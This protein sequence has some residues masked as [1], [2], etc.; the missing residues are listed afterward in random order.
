MGLPPLFAF[1]QLSLLL[2][3][4][5][6]KDRDYISLSTTHKTSWHTPSY[7]DATSPYL[8]WDSQ[9]IAIGAQVSLHECN[10][11]AATQAF[12]VQS[13]VGYDQSSVI[14]S[15]V[16]DA[17]NSLCVELNSN[18]SILTLAPCEIK[19][20]QT[21]NFDNN[22]NVTINN[23]NV[24]VGPVNTVYMERKVIAQIP[25]NQNSTKIVQPFFPVEPPTSLP[26]YF[27]T[28]LQIADLCLDGHTV[29]AT[30]CSGA[31]SQDWY[32]L[33]GQIRNVENGLCIDALKPIRRVPATY[34]NPVTMSH[35]NSFP[36]PPSMLWFKQHDNSL[37]NGESANCMRLQENNVIVLGTGTCNDTDILNG[38]P[39]VL[40]GLRGLGGSLMGLMKDLSPIEV[41]DFFRGMNA[42][43]KIPSLMGRANRYHDY[44]GLHAIAVNWIHNTAHFLS[45]HRYFLAILES[46][47]RQ[48]LNNRT[49]AFPYWAWGTSS[50][51]WYLP[52]TGTTGNNATSCVTDGFMKGTW[53]PSDGRGCLVRSYN[54]QT[55]N[56]SSESV[57]LYSEEYLLAV[58][59]VNLNTNSSYK[60]GEFDDFRSVVEN[61]I[62]LLNQKLPHATFHLAMAGF[63]YT[64]QIENP[65]WSVNDPIFWL[66]HGNIDRYW[67]YWQHAN[68]SLAYTYNGQR[69][70][71]PK[72][73]NPVN[74]T[75]DDILVGFNVN[76]VVGSGAF[77][78]TYT[79]YSKSV[80]SIVVNN[81]TETEYDFV[82]RRRN[83]RHSHY[84]GS[85]QKNIDN[86]VQIPERILP[87]PLHD[88]VF[89]LP[90]MKGMDT[91]AILDSVFDGGVGAVSFNDYAASVHHAIK[92]IA[93]NNSW[94]E[95]GIHIDWLAFLDFSSSIP[96]L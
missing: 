85:R 3:F 58:V 46:D 32:H 6:R 74:V 7:P 94:E 86:Y 2:I 55:V 15:V 66:H 71:P 21:F 16:V 62:S 28:Q 37:A 25:C 63:N 29:R 4:L 68:P 84:R 51:T 42:L 82:R 91:D 52:S 36:P 19:P 96:F 54:D 1:S 20:S 8:C 39:K 50:S 89:E 81:V 33:W 10:P 76:E 5:I 87:T 64:A 22:G 48:I 88:S 14:L 11:V 31:A 35:C 70:F 57:A 73:T 38:R 77:C 92:K 30:T 67:K 93:G 53:I 90:W 23:D 43:L 13:G 27:I 40:V 80:A 34:L 41:E 49:F 26:P 72:R 95:R 61:S 83:R 78:Y 17:V 18:S 47:L 65:A 60:E 45:W 9:T 12:L 56:S 79:P 24:C 44:V 75:V 69:N 59:N